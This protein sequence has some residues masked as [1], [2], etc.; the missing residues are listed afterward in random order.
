MIVYSPLAQGVLSNKYA[1]NVKPEG[2]RATTKL[3]HFLE[4]EKAL[5]PENVAAVERFAARTK[6]LGAWTPAQVALAWV[7]RHKV[8]SA[9]IIGATTPAQLEE[10]LVAADVRFDDGEWKSIEAAIAG[11]AP[12]A[13]RPRATRKAAPARKAA[14]ARKRRR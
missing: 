2:S 11:R 10:N 1:G 9:A 4:S 5:T 13:P 3:G 6:E 8:V 12:A 14:S 7:L